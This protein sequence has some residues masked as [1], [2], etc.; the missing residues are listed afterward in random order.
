MLTDNILLYR[1]G[2]FIIFC[3]P[4]KINYKI[5]IIFA[6][7]YHFFAKQDRENVTHN[8]GMIFKDKTPAEIDRIK[9]E[10]FRNFAKYLVDFLRISKLNTHNLKD[11]MFFKN[12]R[13]VDEALE[14][15]KGAII[16][17]AHLGN[18]ELGGVSMGILGYSI[19]AIVLPHKDTVVNSFFDFQRTRKNLKVIHFGSAVR[20]CLKVLSENCL[21][22]I[23]GDK[24]FSS[25]GVK[26]DFFGK[27]M[28][29]PKGPAAFSIM[30]GAPIIPG[31]TI[32]NNDNTSTLVF[33]P[34]IEFKQTG[35][36]ENDI[37]A[38]VSN[39]K[40]VI[41]DYIRRYPQQWYMFKKL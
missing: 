17:S 25:G 40:K 10:L 24:D 39:Y 38:L 13:Y 19:W 3:F 21:L 28:L 37:K 14:K 20:Q 26:I 9:K 22:A 1:I 15:G 30:T 36:R 8:L 5:A 7:L 34:P 12:L 27:E 18:W 16:L 4:L 33:E 41:E 11:L 29:F 31:F 35:N 32:R 23:V 6:D 2:Q